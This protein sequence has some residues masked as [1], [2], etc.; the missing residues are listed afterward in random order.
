MVTVFHDVA[1]VLRGIAVV[2]T[3]LDKL[4]F[5]TLP[6]SYDRLGFWLFISSLLSFIFIFFLNYEKEN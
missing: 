2:L 3:F 5:C 1:Y 4:R 6:V